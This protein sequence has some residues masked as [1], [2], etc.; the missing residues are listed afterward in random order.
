MLV[1]TA[2]VNDITLD[3]YK[4]SDWDIDQWAYR[5]GGLHFPHQPIA[6]DGEAIESFMIANNTYDK[7]RHPH[8]ENSIPATT[9]A[10][11]GMSEMSA[12]LER[13]QSLNLSGLPL[14]NSRV[15]ELDARIGTYTA[16]MECTL[17]LTYTCVARAYLDNTLTAI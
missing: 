16:P 5:L 7:T 4:S 3:S 2:S 8:S 6:G 12:S 13:D 1:D 10:T 15:L 11:G 9:F 17:F 14:N